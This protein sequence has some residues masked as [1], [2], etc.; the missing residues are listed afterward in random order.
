MQLLFG[1]AELMY[2]SACKGVPPDVKTFRRNVSTR[3]LVLYK[4]IFTP[5]IQQRLL[6]LWI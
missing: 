5:P 2:E 3:I 1:I 4:I 6:F